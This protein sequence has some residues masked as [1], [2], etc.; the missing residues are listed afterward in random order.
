MNTMTD[1]ADTRRDSDYLLYDPFDGDRDVDVRAKSVTMVT[2]R[3]EH[4][5]VGTDCTYHPIPPGTR[6]RRE[7]ALVDGEWGTY[8]IC[9]ACMDKWLDEI[10]K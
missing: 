5:C 9:V 2:T 10:G 6:A 7:S 8:Y 4:Q 1:R 3:T